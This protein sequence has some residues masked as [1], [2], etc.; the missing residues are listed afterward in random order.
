MKK[1]EFIYSSID[2][3]ILRA[4]LSASDFHKGDPSVGKIESDFVQIGEGK[5][6]L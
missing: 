3:F 1:V 6:H 4:I 2:I 5:T